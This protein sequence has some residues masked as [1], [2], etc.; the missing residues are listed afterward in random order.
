MEAQRATMNKCHHGHEAP[1]SRRRADSKVGACRRKGPAVPGGEGVALGPRS[2]G[3]SAKQPSAAPPARAFS[4]RALPRP[5]PSQ[6]RKQGRYPAGEGAARDPAMPAPWLAHSTSRD[7]DGIARQP[8]SA[9]AQA[10]CPTP[11]MLTSNPPVFWGAPRMPAGSPVD[12]PSSRASCLLPFPSSLHPPCPGGPQ[13]MGLGGVSLCCWQLWP[14]RGGTARGPG[15]GRGD[16]HLCAICPLP[17]SVTG[18]QCCPAPLPWDPF[19]PSPLGHEGVTAPRTATA[20]RGKPQ[21]PWPRRLSH[22]G[23]IP[24]REG[25]SDQGSSPA[26]GKLQA[27]S[28]FPSEA[29]AR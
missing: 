9:P 20:P 24:T 5:V 12:A 8:S 11:A 17:Q 10:K 14:F 13:A 3:N 21:A 15:A 27:I 4:P 26:E 19:T 2:L 7:T 28:G 6:A 29:C 18:T 16:P 25:P 1:A 22:G 23:P